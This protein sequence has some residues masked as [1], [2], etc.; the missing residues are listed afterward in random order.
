MPCCGK[1]VP[2]IQRTTANRNTSSARNSALPAQPTAIKS[3][4]FRYVGK[5]GLTV[6]GPV[7]AT[8]YRFQA[9]GA[10]LAVDP[11]DAAS[12]SRVPN[13]RLVRGV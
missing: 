10:S 13:L 12:L 3:A 4:Y 5:T 2:Q 7:S 9:N 6:T 8:L 1:A 11:R